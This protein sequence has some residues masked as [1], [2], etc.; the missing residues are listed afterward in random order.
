M[1]QYQK[2]LK[3]KIKESFP[4][5]K[6]KCSLVVDNI[7]ENISYGVPLKEIDINV[8]VNDVFA[9]ISMTQTYINDIDSPIEATLTFPS[10]KDVLVSQMI[11][12]LDDKVIESKIMKKEE[13]EEKYDDAIA[14]GKSAFL[15]NELKD[16]QSLSLNVG[17]ILPGQKVKA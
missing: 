6:N 14:S 16:S 13:A 7:Q 11:V 8:V 10:E 17:N 15:L 3:K 9:T 4:E 12:T 2:V 5:A 1:Q